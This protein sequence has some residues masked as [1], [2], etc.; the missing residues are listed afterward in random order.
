MFSPMPA[1]SPR[2]IASDP[3]AVDDVHSLLEGQLMRRIVSH[4]R[5]AVC[6]LALVFLIILGVTY[7]RD[8][9]DKAPPAREDAEF[10]AVFEKMSAEK[11]KIMQRHKEFLEGRYDLADR[12]ARGV[13]MTR[14]K[15]VQEGPRA[16]LKEGATWEKLAD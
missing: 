11:P 6:G 9:K 1:E 14:G 2:R 12:P 15:A 4:R 7:A 10:K 5:G 13:K 3:R 8:D 16:K